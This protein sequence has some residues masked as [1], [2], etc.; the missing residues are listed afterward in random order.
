[1]AAPLGG[2]AAEPFSIQFW[3]L[4][5]VVIEKRIAVA[6]VGGGRGGIVVLLRELWLVLLRLLVRVV[7]AGVGRA[8]ASDCVGT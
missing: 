7:V 4:G 5:A 6:V 8:V 1:M 2:W 3:A